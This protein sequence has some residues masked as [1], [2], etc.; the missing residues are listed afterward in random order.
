MLVLAVLHHVPGRQFQPEVWAPYPLP[1]YFPVVW[2]LSCHPPSV[3]GLGLT[4]RYVKWL[5]GH[6]NRL[7]NIRHQS[8]LVKE[9]CQEFQGLLGPGWS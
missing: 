4:A 5:S 8:N 3:Y 7:V 2:A 9:A 1:L 6:A